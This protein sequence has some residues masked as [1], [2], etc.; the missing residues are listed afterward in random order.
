M[1]DT[2]F[3][4]IRGVARR[5]VVGLLFLLQALQLDSCTPVNFPQLH[6]RMRFIKKMYGKSGDI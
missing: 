4:E 2:R 5:A 1:N 3:I 6:E